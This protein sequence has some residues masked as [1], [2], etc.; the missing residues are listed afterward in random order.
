MDD[1]LQSAIEEQEREQAAFMRILQ[2]S[3]DALAATRMELDA[4]RG[5]I[6]GRDERLV[7]LLEERFTERFTERGEYGGYGEFRQATDALVAE[8]A[9][10][11]RSLTVKLESIA[12]SLESLG[13]R[14]QETTQA[15]TERVGAVERGLT[16]TISVLKGEMMIAGRRHEELKDLMDGRLREVADGIEVRQ[17]EVADAIMAALDPVARIMQL[18]QGRMA[19]AASD[20]AVAQSTLFTRLAEREE[21]LEHQRD[22][23]LAELL[24]EFAGGLRARDRARIGSHLQDADEQRKRRRDLGRG[25]TVEGKESI[26]AEPITMAPSLSNPYA[27]AAPALPAARVPAATGEPLA[28]AGS[29]PAD[30]A[31]TAA[32]MGVVTYPS[33]PPEPTEPERA[34]RRRGNKPAL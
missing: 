16:E 6:E 21:R 15:L 25:P 13:F 10:F 3:R 29:R 8:Q 24:E 11:K 4:L 28:N 18:V 34:W 5:V 26:P 19:R 23:I 27:A 20:L 14:M 32:P 9:A 12:G 30:P 22:A 1:L 31:P 17:Q 33:R 2:S 7:E